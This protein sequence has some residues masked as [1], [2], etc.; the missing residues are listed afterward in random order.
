MI[1]QQL[2]QQQ[3]AIYR[4]ESTERIVADNEHFLGY[5]LPLRVEQ[6]I[7]DTLSAFQD[8]NP[9][10]AVELLINQKDRVTTLQDKLESVDKKLYDLK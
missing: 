6:Q 10:L 8:Q 9:E 7:N 5:V 3:V 4:F 1:K 2:Q